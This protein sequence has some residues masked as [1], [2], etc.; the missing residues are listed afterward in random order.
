MKEIFALVDCNNFYASCE[1]V[2]N[3][4]LEGR[5]VVVLSNNDGCVVARSNEA[6]AL[7]I[8]MGVPAFKVKGI[9]EK[10]D[11][12]VFSSN[13]ALYADMSHRVMR[14]LSTSTPAM[15]IYSIDEAFLNLAGCADNLTD[16]GR[17]IQATVKKWTG[18]PVSIGIAPTKTLA[19][20]ANRIAKGTPQADGVFY[21]KDLS[22]IDN[23][24]D[25][26]AVVD[27]WGVGHRNARK[28]KRAGI[29]TALTLKN[30][31]IEWIRSKFGVTGVKTVY[32]LR[33]ICCY[34][35]EENPPAKKSITV[36]RSF[37]KAVESIDE[38]QEAIATYA[39]RAG[40]KLRR[41]NL[42]ANVLTVFV[43]TSYFDKQKR[44]F[45]SETIK[46]PSPTN[47][48]PEL[49]SYAIRAVEQLYRKGCSFKKAGV[50][51][52]SLELQNKMQL[53][54]FDEIDRRKT[55]RLMQAVDTIKAKLPEGNLR[56]AAEGLEQSWRTHFKRRS[57]RYTTRWDELLVVA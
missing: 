55:Q 12:E 2:F 33:G 47:Y 5:A 54:L 49:I 10:N 13:Y 14:T 29:K 41:E 6:K 44:Y 57:H 9:I 42:V 1:R 27:V 11:V 31:D 36:S 25:K 7:G 16:Y 48:T 39:V 56:W 51:L 4:R 19:K 15:E 43:R 26:I 24:L 30:V 21:L 40:E 23:L 53:T 52:S 35:L 34:R 22:D 45:N 37:G 8:G 28:L 17:K 46:L 20:I 3:P 18:M 38:L 32:E 50:L